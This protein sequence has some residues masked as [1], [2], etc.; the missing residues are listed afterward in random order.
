MPKLAH[1]SQ[2]VPAG[3]VRQA[4]VEE[5]QVIPRGSKAL[6]SLVRGAHLIDGLAAS[7]EVQDNDSP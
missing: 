3:A 2:D 4:D 6:D 7:R 1:L 5:H